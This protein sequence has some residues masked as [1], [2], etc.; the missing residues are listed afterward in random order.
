[1]SEIK[2]LAFSGQEHLRLLSEAG[3][4]SVFDVVRH[5]RLNFLLAVPAVDKS[6]AEQIYYA[7]RTRG[8]TLK[9]L[10]RSWQL[11]Q[12]PVT[13]GLKK[14]APASSAALYDSVLRDIG[15]DDDFTDLME[16]SREY[17]DA[18]SIQ[19]LFSPGRYAAALYAVA[20]KLH[21]NNSAL[22]IDKR[23][24][25]LQNLILSETTMKQEVTS[26]D[27]LLEVLQADSGNKMDTLATS[28]FPM[29]LPYD[30]RLSRVIAA[31]EAQG[32][33]L[34]GVWK[35][36]DDT[37]RQA[38]NS[39]R[40]GGTI[41][42]SF[43]TVG[44]AP[45]SDDKDGPEFF[46]KA[47]GQMVWLVNATSGYG[48]I[49]NANLVLGDKSTT[50]K[51]IA[52]LKLRWHA[53]DKVSGYYLGCAQEVELNK[54]S[55][56]ET[57]LTNSD[58]G[59]H[60]GSGRFAVLAKK[61][62]G[63]LMTGFHLAVRLEVSPDGSVMLSTE[64]GYIGVDT[65]YS[66]NNCKDPLVLNA[67]REDALAFFL[68]ADESGS[69]V[70]NPLRPL[71]VPIVPPRTPNPLARTLLSLTP[72]S[73]KLMVN[74]KLTDV[75]I[76]RHYGISDSLRQGGE[77]LAT[78]LNDINVFNEKTGLTFNQLLELTAQADYA[79][80]VIA[81]HNCSPFYK[82]GDYVAGRQNVYDYGAAF[83]NSGL[84]NIQQPDER[85]LWVQPEVRA[86]DG[87]ITT[88][89]QLN[90]RDET[91]VTLAGN[92]EKIIR[93][94]YT[95]GLSFTELDWVII[96]A[97]RAAGYDTPSLDTNVL[98]AL[99]AC[100]DLRRR[101]GISTDTFVSFIGAVNPYARKQ[102]HSTYQTLFTSLDGTFA[103]SVSGDDAVIVADS[104]GDK[105]Q[106]AKYVQQRALFCQAIGV[107][108]DELD[109]ILTYCSLKPGDSFDEQVAGRLLRFGAIPRMLGLTFAG[110]ECLWTMMD[111]GASLYSLGQDLTLHAIDLI[112]RSEQ[113]LAWMA[114]NSLTMVQVQAMVSTRFSNVATAEMFTFLQ[115]IFHSVNETTALLNDAPM[116]NSLR[117][118]ILHA[119]AGG[120]GIK[121]REAGL[122]TDW[123]AAFS[124]FVLQIWW[125]DIVTFFSDDKNT[126][127]DA[128]QNDKTGL[129]VRTQCLSQ[130]VVIARWLN[131]TE[132]DLQVLTISPRQLDSTFTSP[133]SPDLSLLLLLTR[134]KRWQTRVTVTRDEALRLLPLLAA[135]ET[136]S[137]VAA[138]KVAV[139]HGLSE[140]TVLSLEKL[141]FG[142]QGRPVSFD[143]LWLLLEWAR[144]G[145]MLNVG[146]TVL[147]DLMTMAAASVQAEDDALTKRVAENLTAGLT[148]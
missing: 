73:Y 101:Y 38:F 96:N 18:A 59:D 90:F 39:S 20:R 5:D 72:V 121:T 133:P 16:R 53:D 130:L 129:V 62:D 54:H 136:T 49:I 148:R 67:R 69:T 63:G 99:S 11:R 19:S 12:E 10:F 76:A 135:E 83:V 109:R 31:L 9:A 146:S 26:L 52:P 142:A 100:V 134:F 56:A 66:N 42:K 24:P 79:H 113:V 88:P 122:L 140:N 8:E 33:T 34:N 104:G 131:L 4:M 80:T 89:A 21:D 106:L 68:S 86:R 103:Q 13:S 40:M 144:I 74:T 58:N 124:G 71:P 139:V 87:K 70:I 14:L 84:K 119:M 32:R 126:S 107:T 108:G 91:V 75:D 115:N 143:Q 64:K 3:F 65:I 98:V 55:L 46:L 15:G 2:S 45:L 110:A 145:K 48:G 7:A 128:L 51:K 81:A 92:A 94:H 147:N 102:E 123:L 132:Q 117:Q 97:S 41:T 127:V 25:D 105:N 43:A 85:L 6:E 118:K 37:E 35:M 23:R 50:D 28:Y 29:T 114:D 60:A 78:R 36:L 95:T 137:E 120:F 1:M 125:Q 61:N 47:G 138:E 57:W 77:S 93:L 30:D 82:N 141:L 22:A 111:G 17:A 116:D 44:A 27:I 112:S